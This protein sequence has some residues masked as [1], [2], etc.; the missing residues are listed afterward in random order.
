MGELESPKFLK[1]EFSQDP[2][3][4]ITLLNLTPETRETFF[5]GVSLKVEGSTRREALIF[6]H[7]YNV[8]FPDAAR[9]TAQIAC[10]LGFDGATI[11]FSWPSEGLPHRYPVDEANAE[12]SMPHFK[13]F[14]RDVAELCGTNSIHIVAHSMGN[15]LLASALTQLNIERFAP[16]TR[17]HHVVLVKAAATGKRRNARHTRWRGTPMV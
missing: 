12:W 3:K 14:L 9:R 17:F 2:S 5:A 16:P 6:V 11:L 8:S 4:H 13:S 10:D 15:R 1:L 7:G